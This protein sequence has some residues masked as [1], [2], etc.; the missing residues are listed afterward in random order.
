MQGRGGQ[1]MKGTVMTITRFS[2]L[3]AAVATIGTA[4]AAQSADLYG[5]VT[6]DGYYAGS[7]KD[8][9]VAPIGPTWYLR[10]DGSYASY[11]TPDMTEDNLF[12]LTETDIDTTWSIGGGIGKY[13]SSTI[14]GD[15]TYEHRFE[16]DAQG[17]LPDRLVALPGF[18]YF[19]IESDVI[20]AN[21]YYD[22]DRYGRINPY[23]GVGLGVTFNKTT[24]GTVVDCGCVTGTIEEGDTTHV[25]AALM[26]GFT[27][28]IRG[29]HGGASAGHF[30]SIKDA[31]VSIDR[32][33]YLDVGYRFLYLGEA[34][35][36]PVRANFGGPTVSQDPTVDNIHAHEIRVGLR[37]E[38][39]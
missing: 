17:N 35:T 24:Q 8:T 31:P 20:L 28:K 4:T 13:F 25:A 36:G 9:V 14:R 16:A 21:L 5:G 12:D 10:V 30:G 39:F 34:E 37:Y 32:G 19:G 26:A 3:L 23:I 15:I 2:A 11:D 38:I 7:M 22:F 29:G 27:A 18:R 1:I 6:N 33:L